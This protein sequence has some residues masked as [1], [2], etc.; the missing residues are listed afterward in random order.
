MWRITL[1]LLLLFHVIF[2]AP[3]YSYPDTPGA[4]SFSPAADQSLSNTTQANA[5]ESLSP[6][7]LEETINLLQSM[8]EE[9]LR[10]LIGQ[11]FL[12]GVPETGDFMNHV[13]FKFSEELI[14]KYNIGGLIFYERNFPRPEDVLVI[15]ITDKLI[16]GIRKIQQYAS[17]QKSPPLFIAIDHEGGNSQPLSKLGIT[18]PIPSP[19]AI[20][21]LRKGYY[22]FTAGS[23]AGSQLTWLG[24]NMN[25]AP[26]ADVNYNQANDLIR[27]RS[28]G[29]MVDIVTPLA[30][31]FFLGQ[32]NAGIISIAKHFPGHG[33][34]KEG[35]D[36]PGVPSSS[37]SIST[38]TN[39]LEPFNKLAECDVEGIMTSHF[40]LVRLGEET[41]TFN[42]R[43]VYDYLRNGKDLVL[44]DGKFIPALK[45]EN[46]RKIKYR[47]LIMADDLGAPAIT[48]KKGEENRDS[49]MTNYVD[50]VT[51]QVIKAFDAGHD[52]LMVSHIFPDS[53]SQQTLLGKGK[54]YRA[55]LTISEFDQI[56][57]GLASHIFTNSPMERT[58]RIKM[59]RQ[60]LTRI[61]RQK[62]LIEGKKRQAVDANAFFEKV[63]KADHT[64][65]LKEMWKKSFFL[66]ESEQGFTG[67]HHLRKDDRLL[68][69][70]PSSFSSY[71]QIESIQSNDYSRVLKNVEAWYFANAINEKFKDRV[72]LF[73]QMEKSIIDFSEYG[74]RSNRIQK[75]IQEIE[76]AQI[77]FIVHNIYQWALI[78]Q[79][80]SDILQQDIF[81]LS[82]ITIILRSYP[83]I[84]RYS[85]P[86]TEGI[87]SK[88]N[89]IIAYSSFRWGAQ[90][91][92][93]MLASGEEI[94]RESI[95]PVPIE[96][97]EPAPEDKIVPFHKDTCYTN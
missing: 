88:V 59:L 18:T 38:L 95:L 81:D 11:L 66:N 47:G 15:D 90:L 40:K 72:Q 43:I 35:F 42:R 49:N 69:F 61:L 73:F 64:N 54:Y 58:A 84:L 39:A 80:L 31:E 70:F 65:L 83:T 30:Y 1:S 60:S 68:V 74:S 21:A 8:N 78:R 5:T 32:Q 37:L 20:G 48:A 17:H 25:F 23:I 82:K 33:G 9:Q 57:K 75:I 97:I 16:K 53:T 6:N 28:F 44:S 10:G 76:P 19:M 85:L 36:T 89:I 67:L 92:A 96:E 71:D 4:N 24:F 29:G 12:V 77:I 41:I 46:G 94:G 62:K 63:N 26:V 27:D 51:R 14:K 34:T 2:V 7:F 22:A 50:N 45:A 52:I 91:L 93:E 13:D 87:T 55:A 3:I 79:V 56:Y 86:G